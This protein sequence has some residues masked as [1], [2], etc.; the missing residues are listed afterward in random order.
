MEQF[1]VLVCDDD[2]DIVKALDI[3]L[4]QEGYQVLKAY[5]G[6]DVLEI[7][8]EKEVHLIILDIMMPGIDGIETARRIRQTSRVPIIMLSAKSEDIDKIHG[9]N[10]GADDYITK[11][12][13]PMELIARVRSGIRRYTNLGGISN[14][15]DTAYVHGGIRIE[16]KTKTVWVDGE[17]VR[18]TPM[19]YKILLLL[20]KNPGRVY[21]SK[22]IYQE[23]CQEDGHG[24]ENTI[25]VHIRHIRE[26]IEINPNDPR[27]ITVVWG[28]GYRME[29]K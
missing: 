17:E 22:Q 21:S 14:Q 27:Y 10:S 12:F 7:L 20:L 28:L 5:Q 24:A 3:Y 15:T 18:F 29:G 9:L 19:E 11:P 2:E 25:A 6:E 16:D 23:V 1:R 8:E 26:K 13:N 4:S